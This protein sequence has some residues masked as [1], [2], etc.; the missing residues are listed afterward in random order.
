MFL[1]VTIRV[2]GC[3]QTEGVGWECEIRSPF[4]SPGSPPAHAG[5]LLADGVGAE[6]CWDRHAQQVHGAW[7]GEHSPVPSYIKAYVVYAY[8]HVCIVGEVIFPCHTVDLMMI[9]NSLRIV[10]RVLT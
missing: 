8:R 9:I 7:D 6:D 4:V 2:R 3:F 10:I 5:T 1:P